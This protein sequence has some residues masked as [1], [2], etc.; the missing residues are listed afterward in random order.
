MPWDIVFVIIAFGFMGWLFSGFSS[1]VFK[2]IC[3]LIILS[4]IF[5]GL[6]I[7]AGML[8]GIGMKLVGV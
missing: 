3:A 5:G 6:I 7:G 8:L 4:A 2:A 1:K